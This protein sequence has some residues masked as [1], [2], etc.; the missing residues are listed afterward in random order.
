MA[1]FAQNAIFDLAVNRASR[2]WRSTR[3]D[4]SAWHART[5][6]A[7]RVPLEVILTTLETKP[8]GNWHWEGG[9]DGAWRPGATQV[10]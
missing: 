10:K 5:R 1:D 4:L 3:G 6:F 9:P 7:N 2:Y 8:D